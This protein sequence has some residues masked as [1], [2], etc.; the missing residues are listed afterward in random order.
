[1]KP[2]W[3][4]NF[5]PVNLGEANP[6]QPTHLKKRNGLQC[7]PLQSIALGCTCNL[8]EVIRAVH[9]TNAPFPVKAEI[10]STSR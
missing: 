1:M 3:R 4:L 9:Y 5:A 2:W 10:P 6:F 8:G 7:N